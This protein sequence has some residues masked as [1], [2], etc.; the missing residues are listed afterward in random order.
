MREIFQGMSG[1]RE[2]KPVVIEREVQLWFPEHRSWR[3]SHKNNDAPIPIHWKRLGKPWASCNRSLK[4]YSST[5]LLITGSF[6]STARARNRPT[7]VKRLDKRDPELDL[8]SE[9]KVMGL[10]LFFCVY[11]AQTRLRHGG[12][13][14]FEMI[15]F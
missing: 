9:I 2:M 7:G 14:A 10:V 12:P 4:T 8:E 11:C 6:T 1:F 13:T 3:T 5:L 15:Q